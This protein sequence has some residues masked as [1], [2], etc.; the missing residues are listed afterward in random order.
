MRIFQEQA[1]AIKEVRNAVKVKRAKEEKEREIR[2]KEKIDALKKTET[3]ASIKA[4]RER[5][6]EQQIHYQ[7]VAAQRERI[8][9]ERILK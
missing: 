6:H 7:G 5:Q 4:D 1:T 8:E 2:Q 9:F 3:I